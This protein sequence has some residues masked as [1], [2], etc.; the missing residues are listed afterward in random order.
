MSLRQFPGSVFGSR[1][2][3]CRVSVAVAVVD[4]A[5]GRGRLVLLPGLRRAR[6]ETP[7]CVRTLG[8]C[9]RHAARPSDPDKRRPAR[10]AWRA[11]RLAVPTPPNGLVSHPTIDH[12]P[13]NLCPPRVVLARSP[14]DIS[15]SPRHLSIA[16]FSRLQSLWVKLGRSSNRQTVQQE[17]ASLPPT[18]R[19][20]RWAG[21]SR[22]P[23]GRGLAM[24]KTRRV[25]RRVLQSYEYHLHPG[26]D[27]E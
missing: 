7:L 12:D 18:S 16:P 11:R 9:N 2:N 14:R 27:A 8:R 15:P 4:E 3:S 17:R 21:A 13:R 26:W 22:W 10:H 24:A 23:M 19:R 20:T 1:S 6:S 5:L 25:V